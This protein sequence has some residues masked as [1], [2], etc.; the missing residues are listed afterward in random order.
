MSTL[1]EWMLAS[2]VQMHYTVYGVNMYVMCE[3]QRAFTVLF[4]IQQKF[5]KIHFLCK[6]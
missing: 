2:I 6:Y 1:S 4:S 5:Y 3:I